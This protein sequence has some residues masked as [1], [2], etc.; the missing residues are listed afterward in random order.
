[1]QFWTIHRRNFFM[2]DL[3]KT[4]L[5]EKLGK[6][7][8]SVERDGRALSTTVGYYCIFFFFCWLSEDTFVIQSQIRKGHGSCYTDAQSQLSGRYRQL[9]T[10]L[11]PSATKKRQSLLVDVDR[12][13]LSKFQ[14]EQIL[15]SGLA[16]GGFVPAEIDT[17]SFRTGAAT[18]TAQL[19]LPGDRI[20]ETGR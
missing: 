20:R 19:G 17:N 12:M 16:R 3:S 2:R 8:Y 11:P 10:H 13:S 7:R 5:G 4:D 14:F 18:P 6:P 15:Q 1:M 9:P